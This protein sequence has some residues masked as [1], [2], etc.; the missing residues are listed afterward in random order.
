MATYNSVFKRIEKK[1]RLSVAQRGFVEEAASADM[2]EDAYGRTR[3]TSLY[4]DTPERA[5]ID[6]SLD[7]PLYKEKLR[8]RAYGEVEGD[9]LMAAFMVVPQVYSEAMAL[10]TVEDINQRVARASQYVWHKHAQVVQSF[11]V[12]AVAHP[13]IMPVF[14]EIKKKYKGIVYKRR[15]SMSLPAAVAFFGGWSFEDASLQWPLPSKNEGTQA[16]QADCA[17][18]LSARVRQIGRELE[19]AFKRNALL[20]ASM[21]ISCE[22]VAWEVRPE[23][24]TLDRSLRITYDDHLQYLDCLGAYAGDVRNLAWEALIDPRESIME[25]KSATS[26]PSWLV[27]VL[28]EREIYPA[29]FTKYGTAY[30][31]CMTS[32]DSSTSLKL[33]KE[34]Y[35]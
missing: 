9:L 18:M 28:S 22:R 20:V 7:K 13:E 24:E 4:F 12:S 33:R 14:F 30:K 10:P 21:G 32:K 11:A 19:A 35:A 34:H 1:Y 8:V 25:I 6:R 5:M 17:G 26:Y 31:C 27:E 29:S 2:R 23:N 15:V 16:A 3:I